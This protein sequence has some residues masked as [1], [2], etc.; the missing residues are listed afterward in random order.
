M[1]YCVHAHIQSFPNTESNYTRKTSK[2]DYLDH[3]LNIRQMYKLYKEGFEAQNK[4]HFKEGQYRK[5]FCESYNLS[6]YK[7]KKDQCSF[8]ELYKQKKETGDILE[9]LQ[10]KYK[11]NLR[12]KE[13]GRSEKKL[14]ALSRKDTHVATLT[15]KPS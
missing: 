14:K 13:S 3:D 7:S 9:D 15:Y 6:F 4:P 5:V 12:A 8:C 10:T 11:D 2:R 1:S